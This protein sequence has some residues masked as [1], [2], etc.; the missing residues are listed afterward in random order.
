[1]V[2]F[3]FVFL[4]SHKASR[5][6]MQAGHNRMFTMQCSAAQIIFP[7]A[8]DGSG[9]LPQ[10]K[11]EAGRA[12]EITL[13]PLLHMHRRGNTEKAFCGV[14]VLGCRRPL[15]IMLKMTVAAEESVR[16]RIVRDEVMAHTGKCWYMPREAEVG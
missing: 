9:I 14:K 5:L 4:I 1:M 10:S 3:C 15:T 8:S 2:L 7:P 12:S 16:K 11:I 13:L 6:V